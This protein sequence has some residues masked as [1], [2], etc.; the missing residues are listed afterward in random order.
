VHHMFD[1]FKRLPDGTPLWIEAVPTLLEAK[2]RVAR[3]ANESLNEYFIFSAYDG[4]IV[5]LVTG[6]D[7]P[8][9][10]HRR[11]RSGETVH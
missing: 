5:S 9:T 10:A 8:L 7:Q 3:M 11:P 1:I 2:Q 6:S 4:G